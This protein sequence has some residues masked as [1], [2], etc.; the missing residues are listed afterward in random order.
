[1]PHGVKIALSSML[2]SGVSPGSPC[3]RQHA[4]EFSSGE[5]E[6]GKPTILSMNMLF[7]HKSHGSPGNKPLHHQGTNKQRASMVPRFLSERKN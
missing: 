5:V 7:L 6:G 1:M 3:P 4:N 2:H